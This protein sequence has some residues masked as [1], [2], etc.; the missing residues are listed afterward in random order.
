MTRGIR[1]IRCLAGENIR[2]ENLCVGIMNLVW[3]LAFLFHFFN[4]SA[5][6]RT[7]H[8]KL[9]GGGIITIP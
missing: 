1:T 6:D 8:L 7:A 3:L 5:K 9:D 2:I 4:N